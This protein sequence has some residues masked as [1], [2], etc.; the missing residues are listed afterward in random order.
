MAVSDKEYESLIAR[1]TPHSRPSFD[2]ISHQFTN[3]RS[4]VLQN[5]LCLASQRMPLAQD[6]MPE[7]L[8]HEWQD[9]QQVLDRFNRSSTCPTERLYALCESLADRS[10]SLRTT[11]A[12]FWTG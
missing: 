1:Q 2:E 4:N 8:L 10:P 12:L 11:S 6:W 7:C 3:W 5:L 9:W